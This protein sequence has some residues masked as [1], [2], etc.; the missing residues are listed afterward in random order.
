MFFKE[1]MQLLKATHDVDL[2]LYG[3]KADAFSATLNCISERCLLGYKITK[4]KMKLCLKP[5]RENKR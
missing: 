5:F 3:S 1:L 4:K 2:G